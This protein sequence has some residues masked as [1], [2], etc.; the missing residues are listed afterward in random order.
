MKRL[1]LIPALALP[2]ALALAA[3]Q[4]EAWQITDP[5]ALSAEAVGYYCQMNLL[6]HPGPKAQAHLEGLPGA[7]LFFSQVRDLVAY[8]RAP[9]QSHRVL[10]V[11]VSDMGAPGAT[12]DSPG[13]TN[14]IDAR[15]AHYVV[16]A[17]IEGGMGAPEFVPFAAQAAAQSF[18]DRHGGRV[19][20]LE[21]IPD[22]LVSLANPS[23][24]LTED[25]DYE[26]RLRALS[27]QAGG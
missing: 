7:P 23:P 5:V 1:W 8:L 15:S 13:A 27:Q 6:E 26:T 18:V 11:W 25:P 21:M 22:A 2:L 14:W 12:W 20:G 3:C 10:A 4:E 19:M 24:A 16:G 9:E 17:T